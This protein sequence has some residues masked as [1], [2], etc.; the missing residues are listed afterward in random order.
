[1]RLCAGSYNLGM[2]RAI[3]LLAAAAASAQAPGV[4]GT[5]QGTLNVGAV[6]LRL[7][8]HVTR[9]AEGAYS[10]TLD[11]LDQGARGLPIQTTTFNAGKLRFEIPNLRA[12]FEG[13]LSADGQTIEGTFTQGAA[14]PLTWKR[15]AKVE[16]RKR[17]QTPRPPFPYD[18]AEVA[19]ETK[20]G[21][22]I[23]G[24]LTTPR[25]GLPAPAVLL[26]TGSGPQDRDE[27]LFEH[28]PFAVLADYLT[29]RGVA[30]L[31]VDDRGIG[32][33]TGR[34]VRTT[35]DEMA[36]D[37]LTG[38]AFL[39]GRKEVDAKRIGL[40]GHSEGAIVGPLAASRS[41][42]VAFVA[43][44]AGT[45]VPGEQV[46]MAQAEAVIRAEGG[47]DAAVAENRAVQQL[48]MD[49]M[50]GAKDEQTAIANAK[51][52]WSKRRLGSAD[53]AAE[54]ILD[55]QIA[56]SA[57][58]EMRSFLFLDPAPALRKLTI[59]VLALNGSRD[60][61][62]SAKQNMP[63]IAAA[64][65]EAGNADF[66]VA[67]LPGLN[68]LFQNCAKCSVSEYGQLEET[69]APAALDVLGDWIIRHTRR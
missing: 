37:V 40:V 62:V 3:L 20:G 12:S 49:A 52:A 58:P 43:M 24:T 25:T 21:V 46:V 68:H 35:L 28:K 53:A 36:D 45:G 9:T 8:L 57:S 18:S 56:A 47:G 41:S 38:V 67:V 31:R 14:F 6:S 30:V 22:K 32:G 51:A 64:L 15:V 29:R 33:S 69:F 54:K 5:W 19:Y 7:G 44:L 55:Q 61:Q 42:D 23:A 65:T 10:S 17:P 39:K 34:S 63:A 1:M 48:L 11:S 50:R 27:T 2:I 13:A 26:I 4:E 66:T 16:E 59:P 60:I